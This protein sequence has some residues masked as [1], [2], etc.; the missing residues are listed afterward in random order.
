MTWR[1]HAKWR[2]APHGAMFGAVM[3]LPL[4]PIARRIVRKDMT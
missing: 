4:V 3:F 2:T 1:A